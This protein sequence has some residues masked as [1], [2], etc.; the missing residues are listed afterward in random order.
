MYDDEKVINFTTQNQI[1]HYGRKGM[2]WGKNIFGEDEISSTKKNQ[3]TFTYDAK[4]GTTV[5]INGTKGYKVNNGASTYTHKNGNTT[6]KNTVK[7]ID[8]EYQRESQY[9][10][11][12]SVYTHKVGNATVTNKISPKP[13]DSEYQREIASN[14]KNNSTVNTTFLDD[15]TR[16]SVRKVTSGISEVEKY[17]NAYKEGMNA[18]L[19]NNEKVD[20]SGDITKYNTTN[21]KKQQKRFAEKFMEKYGDKINEALYKYNSGI[22]ELTNAGIEGFEN[23]T[24]ALNGGKPI[25]ALNNLADQVSKNKDQVSKKSKNVVYGDYK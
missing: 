17:I 18:W 23:N 10:N 15:E 16:E 6:I 19:D 24:M 12:A 22:D 20:R 3:N 7:P 4:T 1:L 8:S 25:D 2:K 21:V 14:S 5:P 9:N 11:G 13:I